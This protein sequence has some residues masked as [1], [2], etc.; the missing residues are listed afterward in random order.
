VR[1]IPVLA[2][3]LYML[4]DLDRYRD[5][6]L[7][8]AVLASIIPFFIETE[9][10]VPQSGG[11]IRKDALD[12]AGINSDKPTE[13]EKKP[14]VDLVPGMIIDNLPPGKTVKTFSLTHPNVN[15]KTFE[16]AIVSAICW[17]NEIPPEM[18]EL[19]Y[20][21]SY[22]ASR[23]ANNEFD[24]YLK[25]RAFKNA[26]DSNQLIYTEFINQSVL[27]GD[28]LLPGY[29]KIM[30][31]PAEWKMRGAWL[32]VEWTAVSRPSV[33]MSKEANAYIALKN[34][35]LISRD[36][37]AR[38][39]AGFSFRSLC[40]IL[41]REKKMMERNGL[42]DSTIDSGIAQLEKN[43]NQNKDDLDTADDGDD[44]NGEGEE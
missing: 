14:Q 2:N 15:F 27:L 12:K 1:G 40:N 30:F 13:P 16:G 38:R 17:S 9:A 36:Q 39:F 11:V 32:K 37:I 26:K 8:A 44:D 41:L 5:A 10:N 4:R 3:A 28:L 33:D 25:Y 31:S 29:Q 18:V 22:S 19:R 42:K 34:N 35:N 7:R 20:S 24:I 23:Q 6:E 43:L 21:T